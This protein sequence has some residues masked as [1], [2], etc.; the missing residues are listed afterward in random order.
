MKTPRRLL[1]PLLLLPILLLAGC[2][3]LFNVQRTPLTIYSP[4]LSAPQN[5]SAAARVTWQL[6]VETPL[7]SNALDTTRILVMPT[8]GVLEVFPNARWRDAAPV[9]LRDLIVQGFQDSQRILGVGSTASGLRADYALGIDLSDFQLEIAAGTAHAAIR[10]QAS[11][12]DYA[13]NRVLATRAFAADV[14]ATSTNAASA[15]AAFQTALG[16]IVPEVVDWTLREGET[17][18]AKPSP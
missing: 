13:T 15:F 10:F 6:E 2:S 18:H 1:P 11:L 12:L 16:T 5:A 3:S 17:A 7:A 4:H 14:P 8:P 9:L